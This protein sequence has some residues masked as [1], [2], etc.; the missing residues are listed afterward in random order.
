MINS[1]E[2]PMASSL[3]NPKRRSAAAFQRLIV[4]FRSTLTIAIA[5]IRLA[6]LKRSASPAARSA[7][8]RQTGAVD[9]LLIF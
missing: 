8:H 5:A 6:P 4:P 3:L 2:F 7:S 1:I 9:Q